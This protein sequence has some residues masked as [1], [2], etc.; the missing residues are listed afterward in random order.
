MR[1]VVLCFRESIYGRR[2]GDFIRKYYGKEFRMIG[3]MNEETY[4][5]ETGALLLTDNWELHS[6]LEKG[7]S[8]YFDFEGRGAGIYPYQ[9]AAGIVETLL[10]NGIGGDK[11]EKET[12][13]RMILFYSPGGSS[14][15]RI[16]A[17]KKSKEL[18]KQ[19]RVL[20][21]PVHDMEIREDKEEHPYDLSELCYKMKKGDPLLPEHIG[22]TIEKKEEYHVMRGFHSPLH[23]GELGREISGVTECICKGTEY[24]YLVL[25]M[26]ILP[27]DYQTLFL[28]ADEIYGVDD[29][30]VV[31]DETILNEGIKR[32]K[33]WMNLEEAEYQIWKWKEVNHEIDAV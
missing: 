9:S 3:M 10:W 6:G 15:Q 27:P 32:L 30:A 1:E 28:E 21:L 17:L 4:Q 24:D 20:Y 22:A 16:A 19:G 33:E 7:E 2:L 26:Q 31:C 11:A 12:R 13:T 8:Y 29:G 25:D 14:T 5:K 18:A 23:I